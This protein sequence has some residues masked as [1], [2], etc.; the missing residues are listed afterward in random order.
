MKNFVLLSDRRS[1][2]DPIR[3]IVVIIIIIFIF[4]LWICI[5]L[6]VI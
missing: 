5:E 6:Q 4:S 2:F 1:L 3:I